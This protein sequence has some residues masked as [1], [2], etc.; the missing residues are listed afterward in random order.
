MRIVG[1]E[2]KA[3]EGCLY[4]RC[5]GNCFGIGTHSSYHG[6]EYL[7]LKNTDNYVSGIAYSH[8]VGYYTLELDQQES[9][10]FIN[11]LMKF[12]EDCRREL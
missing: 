11:C 8:G 3:K 12:F 5:Q 4:I 10:D 2:D 1:S 7:A 6:F 9:E